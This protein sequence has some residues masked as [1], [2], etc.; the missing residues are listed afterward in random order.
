[1]LPI[2]LYVKRID[3]LKAQQKKIILL[4]YKLSPAIYKPKTRCS[5]Y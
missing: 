4:D 5:G 3:T 1:M 2:V